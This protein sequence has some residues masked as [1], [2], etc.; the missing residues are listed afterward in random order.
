[1]GPDDDFDLLPLEGGYGRSLS[2]RGRYESDGEQN[3]YETF[4]GILLWITS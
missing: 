4:H 3:R 1:M 2:E